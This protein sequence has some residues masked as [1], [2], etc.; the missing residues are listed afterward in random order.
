MTAIEPSRS[1]THSNPAP[2]AFDVAVVGA[3]PSGLMAALLVAGLG[4][5]TA[6]I[7][8]ESRPDDTR[9]TALLGGSV[10]LLSSAW[11]S[12]RRSPRAASRSKSC[13]SSTT[14]AG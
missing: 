13:G 5:E 14:P 3:G 4:F 10:K 11:A 9:T 6:L 2:A 8:P 7:A 12:G 1:D